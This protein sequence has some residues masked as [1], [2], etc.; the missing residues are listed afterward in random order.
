MRD[1]TQFKGGELDYFT[2]VNL[3]INALRFF[4]THAISPARPFKPVPTGFKM[5]PKRSRP[6]P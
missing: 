3:D 6:Q 2:V 4:Q 5:H 1:L